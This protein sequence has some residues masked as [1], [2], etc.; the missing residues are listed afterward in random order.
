MV[1]GDKTEDNTEDLQGLV[2]FSPVVTGGAVSDSRGD[3]P[4]CLADCCSD[5]LFLSL[6]GPPFHPSPPPS[7]CFSLGSQ[8]SHFSTVYSMF[9]SAESKLEAFRHFYEIT[10]FL[11]VELLIT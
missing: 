7:L 3:S 10:A 5:R 8:H 6:S 9:F 11:H 4:V 2:P 1:G